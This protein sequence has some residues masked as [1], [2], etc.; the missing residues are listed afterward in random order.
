MYRSLAEAKLSRFG[1]PTEQMD[2]AIRALIDEIKWRQD[3]RAREVAAWLSA[4]LP[5]AHPGS[6][7]GSIRLAPGTSV[8]SNKPKEAFYSSQSTIWPA[9][10]GGAD[11]RRDKLASVT[12]AI[13]H[14]ATSKILVSGPSGAGKSTLVRRA[15]WDLAQR[16]LAVVLEIVDTN[17]ILEAW[18]EALRFGKRQGLG[19]RTVVV[20]A[21]DLPDYKVLMDLVADLPIDSKLKVIATT[22]RAKPLA[23]RLGEGL[24]EIRLDHISMPEAEA[25]AA[26]LNCSLDEF[27]EQELE[28]IRQSGQLLLLNLV[29]LGEG[30]VER[31][32][33]SLLDRLRTEAPELFDPYLDLCVFG[34]LDAS[35]P[36]SILIRRNPAASRLLNVQETSGLV[37]PVGDERMRSGHRLLSA[38]I[39]AA[40]GIE[41]VERM[42]EVARAADMEFD[43]ERRFAVGAIED[44]SAKDHVHAARAINKTIAAL[45]KEIVRTGDYLDIRRTSH[46]LARIGLKRQAEEIGA[47]ATERRIRTGADAAMFRSENERVEPERTFDVLLAF[48]DRNDT[49]WGWRNFLR[50]ASTLSDEDRR[51]RA[52]DQA[53]KRLQQPNLQPADG[54][55][56]VDLLTGIIRS[57][58][59][60]EE[61]V[62]AVIRRF[63]ASLMIARSLAQAVIERIRLA[64]VFKSLLDDSLPLLHPMNAEELRLARNLTSAAVHAD[65]RDRLRLVAQLTPYAAEQVEPTARGV[66]LSCCARI[67]DPKQFGELLGIIGSPAAGEGPAVDRAQHIIARRSE[68]AAAPTM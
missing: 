66:L 18:E 25:V 33:G 30:S 26:K 56:V 4:Y 55:V 15:A 53:R 54:K 59:W 10:L 22:W 44:S 29:L 46:S 9:I 62:H 47:E 24:N 51:R 14:P 39:V 34:R 12:Q 36:K 61:L 8:E 19:G 60:A 13:L 6:G 1:V 23:V 48:Y 31:F 50:F 63:P 20:I 57:P 2:D 28:R 16:G 38:A 49:Q 21:D 64:T 43:K 42:V 40:S 37:F 27:S 5:V 58:D 32:A 52:L 45:A 11:I 3:I 41:P 17:N 65:P 67:A 7:R 35:V 68:S